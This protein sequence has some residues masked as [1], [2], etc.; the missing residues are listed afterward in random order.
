MDDIRPTVK[1]EFQ[2]QMSSTQRM[3]RS[4]TGTLRYVR[5]FTHRRKLKRKVKASGIY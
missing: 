5:I 4:I 1:Y 2:P 3:P